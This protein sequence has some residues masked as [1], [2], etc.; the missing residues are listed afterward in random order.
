LISE[1]IATDEFPK[2]LQAARRDGLKIVWI[3]LST[4]PYEMTSVG[5][6]IQEIQC[7]HPVNRPLDMMADPERNQIFTKF[8]RDLIELFPET[9]TTWK[10]T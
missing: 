3:L 7:A 9:A 1:F 6:V 4:A 2:I 5:R 8:V 10:A